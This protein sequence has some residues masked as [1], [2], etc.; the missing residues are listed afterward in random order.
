MSAT[1]Q[2]QVEEKRWAARYPQLGTG[3]VPIEPCVSPEY[4]E[5]ERRMIFRRAWL[6]VGRVEEIPNPGDYFTKDIVAANASIIVVRGMDGVVRA[7]H[8]VCSHRGNKMAWDESGCG[9]SFTCSF[10]AWTYGL[11]G[12]L[13][14][15]PDEG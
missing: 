15:V 7:F 13:K 6:N 10:H 12:A 8:N 3:P 11:D 2:P 1:M 9:R 5:L 4:F 14:S